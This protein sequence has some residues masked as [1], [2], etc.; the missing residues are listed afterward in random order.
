MV[1]G[2]IEYEE[3]TTKTKM[4]NTRNKNLKEEISM[5]LENGGYDLESLKSCRDKKIR[6]EFIR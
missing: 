6:N 4:E 2:F 5:V 1:D 3:S